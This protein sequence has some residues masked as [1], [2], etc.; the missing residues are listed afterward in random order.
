MKMEKRWKSP[1]VNYETIENENLS[2]LRL[3]TIVDDVQRSIVD[4]TKLKDF[5]RDERKTRRWRVGDC[6][7]GFDDYVR[8]CQLKDT[9]IL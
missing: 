2:L 4:F 6:T 3:L 5:S 7:N 8:A 1:T 9:L